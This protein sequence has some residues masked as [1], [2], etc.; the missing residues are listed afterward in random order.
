MNYFCKG[1]F[2][3]FDT[4]TLALYSLKN[5]IATLYLLAQLVNTDDIFS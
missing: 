1:H 5:T 4:K 2:A 3:K